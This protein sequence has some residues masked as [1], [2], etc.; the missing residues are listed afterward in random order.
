MQF[1]YHGIGSVTRRYPIP[2]KKSISNTKADVLTHLRDNYSKL[3]PNDILNAK[4]LSRRRP[5]ILKTQ[6]IPYCPKS[7]NFPGSIIRTL[8]IQ[9]QAMNI[10]FMIIHRTGKFASGIAQQQSR[11]CRLDSN[12][13]LGRQINNNKIHLTSLLKT[14]EC[15]NRTWCTMWLQ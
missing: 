9:L 5:T 10:D 1:F 14:P 3:I 15:T 6:S 12:S 2:E 13:F 11:R 4:T 7:N 8:Y